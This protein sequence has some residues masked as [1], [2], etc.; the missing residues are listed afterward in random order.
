MAY[1]EKTGN[2]VTP[3]GRLSFPVLDQP[4][5]IGKNPKPG[6]TPKWQ[7]TILFDKAAQQTQDFKDLEAAVEKAI[8]EKWG[9]N[10]PR[11]VK[12]PLL[13][14]DDLK[15]TVPAGY[16][17]DHVFI[18]LASANPIGLVI[19]Q[20]DGTLKRVDNPAEI[21]REFYAGCDVKVSVNV[22]AWKHDEGGCGVS[23]GL[24]NVMKV[25]ENEPFGATNADAADDFG[26]PVTGGA[27][28]DFL[29]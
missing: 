24:A 7:A 1:N 5:P 27:A 20:P 18:R 13:T 2:Y 3:V 8:S 16:T 28:D 29:G 12:S 10:R 4:K 11:K 15:N 19:R 6:D 21:K 23:F 26:A 17:E 25:G 9:A 22:Y 14:I